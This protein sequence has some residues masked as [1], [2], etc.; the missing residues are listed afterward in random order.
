MNYSMAEI[1]AFNATLK[2]GNFTRAAELLMVSQPAVTAQIRK[3]ES[4]FTSPLL[5]RFSRG[6][7]ATE[8]GKELHQI[9]RQFNDLEAAIEVLSNPNLSPGKMTLKVA[10]A[11]SIIFMP[12]IAEFSRRYPETTLK[13]VSVTTSECRQLVLNR[14]VDIGLFPLLEENSEL[15]RFVF[16][17]HRLVA[18]LQPDH[19]LAKNTELSVTDLANEPLIVYRPEACTQQFLED[20]FSRHELTVSS[21]VVVDGRLDMSEAVSHGLGI[22]FAL[23]QDIHPDPRLIALPIVEATEEVVEHVVWLNNRRSLP[24]IRDFIQLALEQRCI[25]L[26]DSGDVLSTQDKKLVKLL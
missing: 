23:Q 4:R 6:V 22:G 26:R 11:S 19:P 9:T 20:L 7:R 8:L 10:N 25:A 24:G 18:V 13:I 15:S 5:E 17:S 21:N 2:A 16:A 12:L 3:L 14:E 1:R